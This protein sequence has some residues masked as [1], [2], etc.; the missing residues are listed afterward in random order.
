MLPPAIAHVYGAV[1]PEM[2]NW[3]EYAVLICAGES[4]VLPM[5]KDV[6]A[7]LMFSFSE[8]V[9]LVPLLSTACMVK[10]ARPAVVGVPWMA[11]DDVSAMPAGSAPEATLHV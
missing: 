5:I 3:A 2:L 11:P 4:V 8:A 7:L 6:C 10:L 9:S 1:P